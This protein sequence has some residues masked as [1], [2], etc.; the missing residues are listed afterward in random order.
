M[1]A[2]APGLEGAAAT[3]AWELAA[4]PGMGTGACWCWGGEWASGAEGAR[5]GE[6]RA[7]S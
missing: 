2:D 6:T 5:A 4:G 1:E 7:I 3:A